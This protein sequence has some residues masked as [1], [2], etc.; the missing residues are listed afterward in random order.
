MLF[1][2]VRGPAGWNEMNFIEIESAVRSAGDGKMSIV[3]G[4]KRSAKK[5]NALRL[6][7]DGGAV[8]LSGGQ[9]GSREDA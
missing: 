5:G 6:V 9:C 1:Q 4:I 7:P 8:R 2:F 3:N